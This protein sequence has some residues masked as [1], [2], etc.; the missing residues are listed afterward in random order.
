MKTFLY[1]K[2][3]KI[4]NYSVFVPQESQLGKPQKNRSFLGG[5]TT[6][7]L[8]SPPLELSVNKKFFLELQKTVFFLV[9]KPLPPPLLVAGPLKNTNIC[10]AASLSIAS[11]CFK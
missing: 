1:G 3:R 10:F 4:L 2:V 8:H 5:P 6:K 7:D 11:L 9:A